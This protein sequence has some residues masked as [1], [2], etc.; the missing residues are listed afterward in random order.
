M[1]PFPLAV[2]TA[3]WLTAWLRGQSSADDLITALTADT[4][5]WYAASP[6]SPP[7]PLIDALAHLRLDGVTEVG[8][9]IT[10]DGD[11]VGL[12][13]PPAVNESVLAA[14]EAVTGPGFV[15]IPDVTGSSVTW[16]R[17]EAASA[18]VP[19]VAEAS[20]GLRQVVNE[21]VRLS[22]LG[23]RAVPGRH[24]DPDLADQL[25]DLARTPELDPPPGIP[26]RCATL[27][28]QG[29]QLLRIAT[30]ADSASDQSALSP[31]TLRT[32]ATAA[33]HA[34]TAAAT[35]SAW[36]PEDEQG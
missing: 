32:M 29:W 21:I 17:H 11:P 35:P 20:R 9:S 26:P 1:T 31:Q 2:E 7:V 30:L 16:V 23:D 10:G 25:M 12:G 28:A 18:P 27:A 33:R 22:V 6:D 13:G 4:V 8:A 5:T 24:F 36:P 15:L 3:W 14:G 34:L 19:D